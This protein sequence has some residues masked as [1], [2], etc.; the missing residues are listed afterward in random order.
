MKISNMTR[1]LAQSGLMAMA[2][3]AGSRALAQDAPA[4]TKAR[5]DEGDIIVTA[6]RRQET[7]QDVP[8]TINVVTPEALARSG[9]SS[10]EQLE[11]VAPGISLDSPP[12]GNGVGIAIRGL[13]SA[14]GAASFDSS[15]SLFID[16]IYAP[17]SSEFSASLFDVERVEVIR[18]TQAA[19][20]GKNTSLG[21]VNIITRKPGDVFAIDATASYEFEF[22]SAR[23]AGGVDL[24]IAEG[25]AV[26][27]S[28]QS[29]DDEGWVRNVA[30]GRNA[31]RTY[32]DAARL[33]AVW[34]PSP[35]V[36]VTLMAQHDV[37][38]NRGSAAEFVATNGTPELL[39]AL[40]G[41]PGTIDARLDRRNAVTDSRGDGR[42]QFTSLETN[43][44]ALTA[45]IDIA[46]YTLTS[47]TGLSK[48]KD[49]GKTDA[50]FQPGDYL[51]IDSGERKR[52]FSQEVRLASPT[53]GTFDFIIGGLYLD[54]RFVTNPIIAAS[55][56]FGPA[57][58]VN[59]AGSERTNFEQVSDAQSLFGQAN[60]TLAPGLRISGGARFTWESKAV[61]L[62]RDILVP[63]FFSIVAYPP[64]APF[65]KSRS[66][67]N[68]D[69]S[70]GVQYELSPQALVYAS[71]GKGTKSGGY[72]SS[73]TLLQD[74]EYRKEVAR[75]AEGGVKLQ[76]ASRDWTLNIA[77]FYTWVDD[78][79][80]ITFNGLQFV[81][82]N[83]DLRSRGVEVEA[84][85]RPT[86]GLKLYLNNTYADARDR[87]T[88]L[89][90]PRA[91]LWLGSAGFDLSTGL[92]DNLEARLNGSVEY[93][94]RQYYQQDLANAVSSD[95]FTT[96]NLSAAIGS[97]RRGWELR[98]IGNNVTDAN[99]V[100]FA[101]PTPFLAGN[102]NAISERGRTISLQ[103]RIEYQ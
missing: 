68:F 9:M 102:Q 77:G 11:S 17:S 33:V 2:L 81:I 93:R 30:L 53:G 39:A 98:L 76:S 99:A 49:F 26:R 89:K 20:L 31:Q 37:L 92:S 54:S 61:N 60:Y 12:N 95:P 10:L 16:G 88:G 15:V 91:P 27:V 75:T 8:A 65:R 83:T 24:P 59:I 57:P 13:G 47:I 72:A 62:S 55:Y 45:N 70:A 7:I 74:S 38:R 84:I 82:G 3:F 19:L 67:Q 56:P 28:G 86:R 14:P 34:Q 87:L 103:L 80:L 48:L 97:S 69:Y 1:L 5:S 41:Y 36:D 4:E 66:E 44:L 101:F 43:K 25:L 96:L 21:A 58:G 100:A 29:T 35:G 32:D 23:L 50:D 63:G 42:E 94:S 18:G 40:A 64:Y 6:R 52:Q 22:G 51:Y 73:V 79:Q 71:Y 90:I 85:W 78:Y 46:G